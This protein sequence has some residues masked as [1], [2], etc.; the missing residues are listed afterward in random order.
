MMIFLFGYRLPQPRS[1]DYNKLKCICLLRMK[2][3]KNHLRLPSC[4]PQRYI[5]YIY[6]YKITIIGRKTG[7][8]IHASFVQRLPHTARIPRAQY[9]LPIC[10]TAAAASKYSARSYRYYYY[11]YYTNPQKY[12]Y[13]TLPMG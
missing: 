9:C 5:I 2:K 10:R 7:Y 6:I 4:K 13:Q 12:V 1:R 3:K 11:Y 8:V